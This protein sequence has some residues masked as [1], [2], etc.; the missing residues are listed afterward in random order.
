MLNLLKGK[1]AQV[2]I[3]ADRPDGRYYPGETVGITVDIHPAKDLKL[4]GAVIKLTGIEEYQYHTVHYVTDSDGHSRT[5]DSYVWGDRQVVI[6]EEKFLG[7][8][9]LPADRPAQYSFQMTLPADALPTC[10]GSIERVRWEV[11]VKLDRRMA[12]DTNTTLDLFVHSRAPGQYVQPG[13]YGDSNEPDEAEL[14]L[15]LDSLEAVTD[16]PFSGQLRIRPRKNFDVTEV[17]LELVRC[18]YVPYDRGNTHQEV[19]PFRLVGK[20]HLSAGEENIIPFQVTVPADA[21]PSVHAGLGSIEWKVKGILARRLRK[22][23]TVEQDFL[24]YTTTA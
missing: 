11:S 1:K 12:G 15:L 16:Q 9:T 23:T 18:E 5:E 2:T 10:K 6:S 19:Y 21:V 8:E 22:D 7:E 4:H 20:T 24:V 3:T 17:R 14:A 13:E